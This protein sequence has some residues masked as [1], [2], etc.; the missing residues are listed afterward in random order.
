VNCGQAKRTI[1]DLLCWWGFW[2]T[3][4]ESVFGQ[5]LRKVRKRIFYEIR[6]SVSRNASPTVITDSEEAVAGQL[7]FYQ[8]SSND[9]SN[10]VLRMLPGSRP[11][12]WNQAHPAQPSLS[13][14][15]FGH[16]FV[17]RLN[18]CYTSETRENPKKN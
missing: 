14:T 13:L 3:E 6:I 8:P 2:A 10:R 5:A 9:L 4:D 17:P 15:W 11:S 12:R 1:C 18:T 7:A 16:S